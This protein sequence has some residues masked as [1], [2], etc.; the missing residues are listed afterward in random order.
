[1][2]VLDVDIVRVGEYAIPEMP[3]LDIIERQLT[4]HWRRPYHLACGQDTTPE[5]MGGAIE[6]SLA[7][8]LRDA[9]GCPGLPEIGV[10][11]W[12]T[13]QGA[14]IAWPSPTSSDTKIVRAA[15]E[16]A[17][18]LRESQSLKSVAS[19][20]ETQRAL[21]AAVVKRIVNG[22]LFSPT[23]DRLIHERFGTYKN[24]VAFER[25]CLEQ[26]RVGKVAEQL[27]RKPDGAGFRASPRLRQR[28]STRELLTKPVG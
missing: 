13:L 21:A 4:R 28:L 6:H 23:R 18:R 17:L 7:A 3:D 22:Y 19:E 5:L 16:E 15:K 11:L 24:Q 26:A 10:V 2:N 14:E 9:G 12:Q 8:M 25:A 20:S 27:L 1:M